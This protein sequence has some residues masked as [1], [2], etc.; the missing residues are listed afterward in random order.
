MPNYFHPQRRYRENYWPA[1]VAVIIFVGVIIGA[2]WQVTQWN[3]C[4]AQ[5]GEYVRTMTG[6]YKCVQVVQP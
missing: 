2:I 5:G 1:V 4:N 3:D 6:Q